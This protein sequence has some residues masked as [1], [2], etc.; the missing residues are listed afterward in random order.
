MITDR[1]FVRQIYL[2]E[3]APIDEVSAVCVRRIT[4]EKLYRPI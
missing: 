2:F 4:L 3:Q 1:E